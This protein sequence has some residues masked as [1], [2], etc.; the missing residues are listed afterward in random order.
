MIT[1]TL[2]I[3]SECKLRPCSGHSRGSCSSTPLSDERCVSVSSSF[4]I[5]SLSLSFSHQSSFISDRD[6]TRPRAS[7]CTSDRCITGPDQR[8]TGSGMHRP[9]NLHNPTTG[10]DCNFISKWVQCE[11]F[12][13]S[14][15][16]SN[17]IY[18]V[19]KCATK[20]IFTSYM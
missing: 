2:S 13:T 6:R 20:S 18:I 9:K 4:I 19:G 1:H 12:H 7:D 11:S 8:G 3:L 14:L 5:I 15:Y 16:M 10:T 17:T